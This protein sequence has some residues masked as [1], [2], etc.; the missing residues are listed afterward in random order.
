M[1]SIPTVPSIIRPLLQYMEQPADQVEIQK[2]VDLVACDTTIAA[3][4]LRMANSSLFARTHTVESVRGAVI[5]L[6]VGRIREILL[7]CCLIRLV[8]REKWVIDPLAFWEHS[9]GCALV[10]RQIAERV[11][12]PNPEKA[13][14]AGLVHDL[15]EVVNSMALPDEFRAAAEMAFSEKVSLYEAEKSSLGFTHCETGRILGEHWSLPGELIEAI[16]YHHDV[17]QSKRYPALVAVVSLSDLLCRMRGLGYGFYEPRQVDFAQ[18]PAWGI[19]LNECPHLK[20]LDLAR[21]T[22]EMDDFLQEVRRLV[23]SVFRN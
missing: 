22:F 19:L 12:F 20:E 15:G 14:L 4:C 6:G 2:I 1:D 9:F 3:Q 21:F 10:S 5:S 8:P 17:E 13:Y 7:S 11:G 16:L 23:E 18:D